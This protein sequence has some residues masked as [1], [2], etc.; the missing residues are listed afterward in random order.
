MG[1]KNA[2]FIH[3]LAEAVNTWQQEEVTIGQKY[4]K[5]FPPSLNNLNFSPMGLLLIE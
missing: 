5:Y 4:G 2:F 3:R 1:T